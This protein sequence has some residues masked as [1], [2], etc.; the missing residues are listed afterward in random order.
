[1]RWVHWLN[2]QSWNPSEWNSTQGYRA[3]GGSKADSRK[4]AE[5]VPGEILAPGTKL[6]AGN[7]GNLKIQVH[8]EN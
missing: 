4:S 7:Y 5:N 6:V 2:F 1:M 8:L 3:P